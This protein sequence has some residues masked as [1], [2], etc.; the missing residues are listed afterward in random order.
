MG[1]KIVFA[2]LI[3]MSMNRKSGWELWIKTSSKISGWISGK[4]CSRN[5]NT[6]LL[7][8]WKKT[9]SEKTEKCKVE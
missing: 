5:M 7:N 1:E 2:K 9:E 6:S 3:Y 4:D 8:L